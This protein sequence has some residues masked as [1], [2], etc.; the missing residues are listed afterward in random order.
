MIYLKTRI[1]KITKLNTFI[2]SNTI[3]KFVKKLKKYKIIEEIYRIQ[4][5]LYVIYNL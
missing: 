1:F 3:Y 2:H 5:I 4:S